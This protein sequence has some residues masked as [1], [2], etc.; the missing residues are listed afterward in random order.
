MVHKA[1]SVLLDP[2]KP[3]PLSTTLKD[4]GD[5]FLD[6]NTVQQCQDANI[7]ITIKLMC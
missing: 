5:I 7:I 2:L 6:F 4:S 1:F 3:R